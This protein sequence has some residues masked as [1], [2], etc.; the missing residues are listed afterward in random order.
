MIWRFTSPPVSSRCVVCSSVLEG[1]LSTWQAKDRNLPPVIDEY[2][3]MSRLASCYPLRQSCGISSPPALTAVLYLGS[4]AACPMTSKNRLRQT[5][6]KSALL[7]RPPRF[8]QSVAVTGW[9]LP[10]S[11]LPYCSCHFGFCCVSALGSLSVKT[12][13]LP[14]SVLSPG[15]PPALGPALVLPPW[16]ALLPLAAQ[17]WPA[18]SPV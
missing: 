1:I 12:G 13:Q 15:P 3:N 6:C 5:M 16:P 9:L 10:V 4:L 8:L 11:S 2:E 7:S 14:V 17:E 18:P